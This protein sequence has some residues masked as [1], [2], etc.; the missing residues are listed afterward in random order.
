MEV[1]QQQVVEAKHNEHDSTLTEV[2]CFGGRTAG[3]L[4]DALAKGSTYK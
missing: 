1:I 3:L 2:K 4:K